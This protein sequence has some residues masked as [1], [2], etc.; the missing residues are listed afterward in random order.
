MNFALGKAVFKRLA[1][2]DLPPHVTP[3]TSSQNQIIT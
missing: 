2:D 1:I 3:V